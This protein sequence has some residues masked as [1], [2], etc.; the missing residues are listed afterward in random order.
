MKTKLTII[1]ALSAGLLAS[2]QAQ[3]LVAGW[4]FSQF[5]NS[6]F[7]TTDNATLTGQANANWVR[8]APGSLMAGPGFNSAP[9]Y[10]VIFYDGSFGSSAFD[11]NTE[12]YNGSNDAGTFNSPGGNLGVNGL[13]GSLTGQGQNF[14]NAQAMS[15]GSNRNGQS[16]VIGI[17]MSSYFD[18]YTAGSNWFLTYAAKTLDVDGSSSIGWEASL[19]GSNYTFVEN[20]DLTSSLTGYTLDLSGAG[21]V[22]QL[23]LRATFN[24]IDGQAAYF[25]NLHVNA[26]PVPEPSAFAAIFG[27]IALG[28]A[29]VRRRRA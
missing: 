3:E 28:F 22:S 11:L 15:I 20:D 7:S 14:G 10:G 5:A 8:N 29:A 19:D 1:A 24:G 27:V 16:I 17:S 25:D 12:V 13:I 21:Q 9:N 23:F 18:G 6:G 2:A 26:S 4:D